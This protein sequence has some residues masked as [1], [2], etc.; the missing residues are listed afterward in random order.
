MTATLIILFGV[1][2]A[3]GY[4][5]Y[6]AMVRRR[7]QA[8]QALSSIDVQLR[9]RHDLVPNVLKLADRFMSH[10]RDLLQRVTELRNGAQQ[11][12]DPAKADEVGQHLEAE[13]AL[14]AGLR[15][16]FAVAENYP[17]LRSSETVV[18]AQTTFAEV[19]GNIAA[20]RRA[21]NASVTN[22]NDTIQI[23]PGGIIAGIAR[24][25]TMPFFEIEDDAARQPV[26]ANDFL[27]GPGPAADQKGVS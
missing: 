1:I 12:Y 25:E 24:I 8:Q 7:N 6:M 4:L 3:V 5:W 14:Q 15:Q 16:L 23:W 17:E 22:L 20:A 2:I 18:E 21:Y 9:K 26:D 11:P 27:N 13:G 10:E 19:E